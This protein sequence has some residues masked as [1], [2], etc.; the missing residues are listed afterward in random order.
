MKRFIKKIVSVIGI[1]AISAALLAGC[2]SKTTTGSGDSSNVATEGAAVTMDQGSVSMGE[3]RLYAYVMRSQYES[4]YGTEI[5]DM[6]VEEGTT[7]GDSMK[8]MVTQQLVQM[9]LLSSQAEDYGVSLSEEDNTAVEEYVTNFKTNIGEDVMTA[10]GITEDD[11]RSVVQKSTLSGNVYEAMLEKESVELTDE[12]KADATCIKVQ[13]VL[14]STT[15]TTTTDADGNTVDMTDEEKTAY[16]EAQKATAEEVL[17][18]ANSGE[19]FQALSDE[20]SADNAGFEFSFDKNGYDPVNQTT[21]VE[22]FYT[23]AWQLG[24]GEISGLV[25]SDY[26]YHIIKCISLNDE[27]AT[28]AS[29]ESAE[30]TKKTTSLEEK[31]TTMMD[32]AKY[33]ESDEWKAFKITSGAA[34]TETT[35]ESGT[36]TSAGETSSET[37]S[38]TETESEAATATTAESE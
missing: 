10:E 14:I 36:T 21:M 23:A 12:E 29:I 16:L 28:Q 35:A 22:P 11:I 31:L 26:G 4:Y 24:E 15:D 27:E 8:E 9:I 17:E 38:E 37:E 6:E 3:A 13:H 19:D 34:T 20:Y 5:W 30:N 7:F 1:G 32:E 25:E 18:K 2:G 33:T